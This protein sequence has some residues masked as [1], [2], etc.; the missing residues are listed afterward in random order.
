MRVIIFKEFKSMKKYRVLNHVKRLVIIFL[1]PTCDFQS[2]FFLI[3]NNFKMIS[4]YIM[5]TYNMII[6]TLK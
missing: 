4:S 3:L 1:D 2:C 6:N 5:I